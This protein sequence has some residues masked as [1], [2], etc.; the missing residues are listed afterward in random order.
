MKKYIIISLLII[1][2]FFAIFFAWRSF[3]KNPDFR[4]GP[5]RAAVI[6]QIETLTRFETAS[7][8]ID[9]IIEISTDYDRLRDFLF[10]D[11]IILIAHGKVIAGFDLSTLDS[12]NYSGK[13]DSIIIKLPA[14]QILET[15]LDNNATSVFDRERGLFTKGEL[16]L[17]ATARQKAESEIRQAACDG[18]ILEEA[19]ENA[20]KQLSLLFEAAGFKEITIITTPATCN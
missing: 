18:N 6:K 11:K 2:G 5:D 1:V 12:S 4:Y 13:G 15:I 9:K 10:G 7:F 3:Q 16:D 17:E 19:N 20:K 8:R 14:P